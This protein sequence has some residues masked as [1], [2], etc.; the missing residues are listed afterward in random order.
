MSLFHRITVNLLSNY[1]VF[2]LPYH[3]YLTGK[4]GLFG[5]IDMSHADIDRLDWVLGVDL[6]VCAQYGHIDDLLVES[7]QRAL[8]HEQSDR[9]Y[10]I[11]ITVKARSEHFAPIGFKK[12]RL[13]CD[14]ARFHLDLCN[15]F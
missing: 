8:A 7:E 4:I 6:R 2:E 13:F 15:T 5:R 1:D 10:H 14:A 11:N 3:V 9:I 12:T